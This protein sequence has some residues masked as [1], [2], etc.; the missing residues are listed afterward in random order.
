[1]DAMTW[2][3]YVQETAQRDTNARIGER[4]G[5]SGPSV[6]RWG[7]GG[8]PDPVVA[9][10]FA[11][12]Y[13]RPVLEAFVAAGFLTAEEANERPAAAPKLDELSDKDLVDAI[14][15]RLAKAK[16]KSWDSGQSSPEDG[17]GEGGAVASMTDATDDDAATVGITP[18]VV[19]AVARAAR[20][21]K[22]SGKQM[23]ADLEQVGPR[24]ESFIPDVDRITHLHHKPIPSDMNWVK[25]R[26]LIVGRDPRARRAAGEAVARAHP[27]PGRPGALAGAAR[28]GGAAG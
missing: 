6:G 11:R 9:A 1:M 14:A 17:D 16:E 27:R 22:S 25:R 28:A 10:A 8:R 2:W 26:E 24:P 15:A 23:D 20:H 4:I 21:G 3:N 19:P 7:R 13:G 18:T 12:A 5:I